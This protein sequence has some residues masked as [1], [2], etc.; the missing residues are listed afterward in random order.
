MVAFFCPPPFMGAA[1]KPIEVTEV[2]TGN[3][4]SSG[5][6]YNFASVSFGAATPGRLLI[7]AVH[8]EASS[9]NRSLVSG[10]IG[11]VTATIVDSGGGLDTVCGFMYA[12]VPTGTS[13]A[14]SFTF[15]NSVARAE[16]WGWQV[17]NLQNP[18]HYDQSLYANGSSGSSIAQSITALEGS[19]A[20]SALTTS[21]SGTFTFN[22]MVRRYTASL[23]GTGTGA[24]GAMVSEIPAGTFSNTISGSGAGRSAVL[25]AFR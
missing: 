9:S 25:V 8:A 4:G 21:S 16:A 13:G 6:T 7:F 23:N 2:G 20:F 18:A 10:T 12:V 17:L 11:G 1:A 3:S 19:V 24:A 15:S 22:N 14:V 5:T